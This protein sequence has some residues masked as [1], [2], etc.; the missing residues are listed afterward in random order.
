MKKVAVVG[1]GIS[2]LVA[3]YFLSQRFDVT[4]FEQNSYLGGHTNTV[5]VTTAKGATLPVDTGFIV[6]NDRTYP[7]FIR[8]LDHL[9]VGSHDTTMS[10]SV[11][12]RETGIEYCGSSLDGLFAQR[13]NL[14]RPSFYRFLR[15][16]LRFG[17]QAEELLSLEHEETTVAE[18]F[19]TNRYSDAFYQRYFLPMGAAIWS[20]PS[21]VFESFPIQFIA[22]FYKNHGLL[23]IKDR[24]QWKVITGGSR[25]YVRSLCQRMATRIETGCKVESVRRLSGQQV[26]V[27]IGRRRDGTETNQTGTNETGTELFDHVVLAC[28]ADQALEMVQPDEGGEEHRLLS[29]FPYQPN[30]A[31]LHTDSSVMPRSRR[32]WAA[33]NYSILPGQTQQATL[34]YDMNRLQGLGEEQTGGSRYFV[35]LN[36]S[37]EIADDKIIRTIS[38]AHPVFS[39]GRDQAQAQH[40]RLIDRDGLSY[41]GAYWGNGFHEDGVQSALRVCQQLLGCDPWKVLSTSAGSPTV[42][43]LPSSTNF[44]TACS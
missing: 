24:P 12:C 29:Q 5:D 44:V 14:L 41:C 2:G 21:G 30:A 38:Y 36:Q 6:F 28:H 33:W 40:T 42:E 43:K 25:Q 8:L 22:R 18:F 32:A 10:F 11:Q 4:L 1:S 13:R 37:D 23:G 20:C 35:T 39:V 34:T 15:D 19:R 27:A 26:E 31:V 7:G 17:K 16:F 3:T 9:G